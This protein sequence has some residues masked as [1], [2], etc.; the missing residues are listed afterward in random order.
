MLALQSDCAPRSLPAEKL[1]RR[2]EAAGA[3]LS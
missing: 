3:I 1:Q 2:L